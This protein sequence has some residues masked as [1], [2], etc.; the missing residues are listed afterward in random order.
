M[1]I[2]IKNSAAVAKVE[3][4][5]GNKTW[6]FWEITK[7]CGEASNLRRKG[8][9]GSNTRRTPPDEQIMVLSRGNLNEK[10]IYYVTRFNIFMVHGDHSGK[11]FKNDASPI[12]L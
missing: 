6:L 10:L 3:D 5:G 1:K 2:S 11:N 8:T 7:F 4:Y 12:L 9:Y